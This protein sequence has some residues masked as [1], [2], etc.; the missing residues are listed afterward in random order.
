MSTSKVTPAHESG[1]PLDTS[2]H[3]F[4]AIFK[5]LRQGDSGL[6][7][8]IIGLVVLG[9][10][11]QVRSSD[12]LSS[13]NIVNLFVQASIFILLGMAEIWV[14]LLGDIDLSLGFVTGIG[15]ATAVIL[16]DQQFHWP[17]FFALPLAVI[18]TTLIGMLQGLIVIRL[19]LPSFIVTLAGF[20]IWEGV[21]I[22]LVDSQGLGG[23]VPVHEK[24]LY[25]LVYANLSPLATWLFVI[26]VVAVMSFLMLSK[27]R[28]RRAN[29]LEST[30]FVISLVKIIALA[31][32]GIV[33]V[34]IFN[35]NRGTFT[36]LRGMPYAIPLDFVV[37]ALG[38][39]ILTRTKAGRYIYAI[40]GNTEA[41][42]RAGVN[43]NGYRL[44]AFMLAGATAGVAGLL[45]ASQLGG[46]SDAIPGGPLV[47]FAVASAVIGGTS[48][49]GGR[50]KMIHAV[51][52]GF[53]IATIY[54]G[55]ALIGMSAA[56]QYMATGLVLLAAVTIDSLARRNSTNSR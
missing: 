29:G 40:G 54:N 23:T 21:L 24:V 28:S 8:I 36:V 44:L 16:V 15:A 43:V 27:A 37:L 49:F 1:A 11:F 52:G 53:V 2:A 41:A 56:T 3:P 26:V 25:D 33:L 42:R 19:K 6:V 17:W 18:V 46:I 7:P 47:L 13:G 39:F 50:G 12:F 9:A 20:L 51:I 30:P 34:L 32:V 55:M 10:Y 45:Y 38:S 35:S 31:L 14:L 48:L 4:S 5:R 22:F